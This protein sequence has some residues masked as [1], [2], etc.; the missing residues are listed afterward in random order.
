MTLM[1]ASFLKIEKPTYMGRF[2]Y[3]LLGDLI[4]KGWSDHTNHRI[5]A[6]Q[7]LERLKSCLSIPEILMW[8]I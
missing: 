4:L 6:A 8:S 7:Y 3:W 1:R 2:R 5:F